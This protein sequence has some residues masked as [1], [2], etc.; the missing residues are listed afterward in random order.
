MEKIFVQKWNVEN[1]LDMDKVVMPFLVSILKRL[2]SG[3]SPFLNFQIALGIG[4][5]WNGISITVDVPAL[6]RRVSST[7]FLSKLG[8]TETEEWHISMVNYEEMFFFQFVRDKIISDFLKIVASSVHE[9]TSQRKLT[10]CWGSFVFSPVLSYQIL[11]YFLNDQ[12]VCFAVGNNVIIL[13]TAKFCFATVPIDLQTVFWNL[14]DKGC[15][16]SNV[17]NLRIFQFFGE[18]D[19]FNWN[20]KSKI[21]FAF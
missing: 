9:L 19:F 3:K 12:F 14:A 18:M 17:F 21:V 15:W 4:W 5:A 16:F 13:T 2:A 6:R 7:F 8:A 1:T 11:C 10:G 20:I